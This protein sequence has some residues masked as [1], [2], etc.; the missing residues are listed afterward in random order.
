MEG[1]GHD[2]VSQVKGFLYTIAVVNV[3]VDVEDPWMVSVTH[4]HTHTHSW[5]EETNAANPWWRWLRCV[6]LLEQLQNA[7]D[8]VI[9]VTKPRGLQ[10]HRT[11]I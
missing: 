3:Y 6:L 2:T 1:H 7:D 4:I 10:T 9:D 8:D 5:N 11:P